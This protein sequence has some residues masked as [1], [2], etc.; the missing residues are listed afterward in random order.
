[1]NESLFISL[2]SY[3]RTFTQ[4]HFSLTYLLFSPLYL[5]QNTL[6]RRVL[7]SVKV[8]AF[9]SQ[10]TNDILSIP[11]SLKKQQL[12]SGA[13]DHTVP[14]KMELEVMSRQTSSVN[15]A[16]FPHLIMCYWSLACCSLPSSLFMRSPPPSTLGISP[17]SSSSFW[18]PH[19]SRALESSSCCSGSASMCELP[20]VLTRWLHQI[21]GFVN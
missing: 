18:W 7:D 16:F 10:L 21:H 20:R 4:V 9:I 2:V 14:C 1:M 11:I 8:I 12:N 17:K 6:E 13:V 3:L 15:L 5:H 19:T